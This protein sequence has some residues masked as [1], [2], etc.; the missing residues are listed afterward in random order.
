[1]TST[2]PLQPLRGAT[3]ANRYRL[4]G[5]LGRGG[6]GAVY[7]AVDL[8]LGRT[9]AVKELAQGG[10]LPREAV[11]AG[12]LNHPAI[13]SLYE[14]FSWQGRTYLVYELVEGRSL[15]AALRAGG[16]SVDLLAAAAADL[17]AALEY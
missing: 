1:M 3:V 2:T 8:T 11:A 6:F 16:L 13:A 5:M 9:V 15:A 4:V 7:R 10:A 17:L 14:A 12:R